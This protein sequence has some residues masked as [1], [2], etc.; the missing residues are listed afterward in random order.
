MSE[1]SRKM[2]IALVV[3]LCVVFT[4]L[5]IHQLT[6][7]GTDE[8]SLKYTVVAALCLSICILPLRSLIRRGRHDRRGLENA[9]AETED[10]GNE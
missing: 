10:K 4:G 9:D 5:L 6:L 2:Q 8:A 1:T 3:S 7:F